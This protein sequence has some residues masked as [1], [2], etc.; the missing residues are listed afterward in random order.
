[1]KPQRH[2]LSLILVTYW[3]SICYLLQTG[4]ALETL[5]IGVCD[6]LARLVGAVSLR[7]GIK[8]VF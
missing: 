5:G 1:M 7:Y 3:L 8:V 6:V 2:R 4:P